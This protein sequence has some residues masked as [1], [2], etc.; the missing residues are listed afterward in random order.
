MKKH[1]VIIVLLLFSFL[2]FHPS[3]A[4]AKEYASSYDVTYN[5]LENGLTRV[6]YVVDLT[7]TTSKLYNTSYKLLLGFDNVQN[8]EASDRL[9]KITPLVSQENGI[10]TIFLK[11][12]DKVVGI[13]KTLRFK[14]SFDTT[15]IVQ[16][17]GKIW[18]VNIPGIA[19]DNNYEKYNV[20]VKVLGFLGLPTYIKPQIDGSLDFSKEQLEESG[21]SIAFGDNQIYTFNLKYHLKNPNL[22]PVTTQIALP[23][24]TNY[25]EVI[26]DEITPRPLNAIRDFDGNWLAKYSLKSSEIKDIVVKGKAKFHCIRDMKS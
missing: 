12:N 2:F 7:N 16:N 10:Y 13:G 8:V 5:V 22:F 20:H 9:G 23:P 18:E 14:I 21:I 11:F 25:Q 15:D 1:L 4:R 3:L 26:I 17:S 24:T 6:E 19:K